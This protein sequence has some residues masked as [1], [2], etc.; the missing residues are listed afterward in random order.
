MIPVLLM[1]TNSQVLM[2]DCGVQMI[3]HRMLALVGGQQRDFTAILSD[4]V[5]HLVDQ[6]PLNA[7]PY[8]ERSAYIDNPHGNTD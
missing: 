3:R 2:T 8:G 6:N 4:Q 1:E 5:V 7:P